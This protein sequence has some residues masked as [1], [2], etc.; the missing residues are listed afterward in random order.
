MG[1]S[2]NWPNISRAYHIL[3]NHGLCH[4]ELSDE[5]GRGKL[6]LAGVVNKGLGEEGKNTDWNLKKGLGLIR[7]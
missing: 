1:Q 6:L 2:R 5:R 3:R 4:Q 7:I